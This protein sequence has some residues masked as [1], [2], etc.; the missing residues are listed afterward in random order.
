MD[1]K[2]NFV[3]NQP[4][5]K[6]FDR[7]SNILAQYRNSNI[8]FDEQHIIANKTLAREIGLNEALILQQINYWIEINKK[9]GNNFYDGRYW[10]YNSIRVWQ[11]KDFDYMGFDA[12]K[13]TFANTNLID[14]VCCASK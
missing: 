8:L 14:V 6:H 3:S 2:N 11:E 10:T 1:N 13:R 12:V 5:V 9:S 7:R 4:A